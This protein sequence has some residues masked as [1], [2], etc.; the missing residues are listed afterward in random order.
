MRYAGARPADQR[1]RRVALDCFEHR[2]LT[3]SSCAGCTST[4]NAGRADASRSSTS[5]ECSTA[6]GHRG[7]HAK[8]QRPY[9]W[10][11]DEAGAYI[12]AGELGIDRATCTGATPTR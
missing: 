2:V 5:C 11:L 9:H 8:A 1:D 3:P 7:S 4:S 6:S 10:V 12:V